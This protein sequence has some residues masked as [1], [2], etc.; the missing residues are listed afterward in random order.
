MEKSPQELYRERE[1]RMNDAIQLKVPDRVPFFPPS[2]HFAAKYMGISLKEAFYTPDKWFAANKKMNMDLEPDMY[3][4]PGFAIFTSGQAFEAVDFK[5]I[6]WPGHGV[7]PNHSFQFVEGEYMKA[8][9]YDA[10]L[11]DPSDFALRVYMPRI[12]G[13]LEPLKMLP[14]LRSMVMGYPGVGLTALLTIPEV[15][16]AFASLYKAGVEA[17][18]WAAATAEFHKEMTGLGF[19]PLAN[20]LGAALAPFDLFSDMLRGM[21]GTMLDMYRQPDKL[22]E[23]MEKVLPLVIETAVVGANIGGSPR[24]FIPLHRGA[25]GFMSKGQF[26]TFYWP[27]L[28]RLLM[29]IIDAGLTPC[30]LFEGCYDSRLE[31]LNDLPKGKIFGMFDRTDVFKAKEIIGDTLCIAG[32]MPLSLLQTGTPEQI[33]AYSKKLIDVVGKGGGFVMGARTA[34][35]EADPELVKVWADFTKEYGVYR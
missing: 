30:P 23:A 35:D 5:Q 14:P 31:Y 27:G 17:A 25:D 7:A 33:I 32:N 28:K 9:E 6:K 16:G 3:W 29:A 11:D 15:A 12:Y 8:N 34:M 26:E 13:T 18:K 19:P 1:K 4:T 21:R 22:L 20:E 2:Q 10:F 24:V